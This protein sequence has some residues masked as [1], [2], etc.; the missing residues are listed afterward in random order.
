S[1]GTPPPPRGSMSRRPRRI[2]SA[3]RCSARRTAPAHT[4]LSVWGRRANRSSPG[5]RR[6]G[7]CGSSGRFTSGSSR[8]WASQGGGT[9]PFPPRNRA[10]PGSSQRKAGAAMGRRAEMGDLALY[11]RLVRQ[12]APSWRLVGGVFL[13]GLLASPLALL[14][15]LPLKIAVDTLLGTHPLPHALDALLPE[16]MRSTSGLLVLVAALAVV[17]TVSSQLQVA[18]QKYLT[19]L[20]G[21]RLQLDFRAQIFRHLQRMSLSYH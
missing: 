14:A 2:R 3:S 18:A 6:P 12:V 15:P 7:A 19:V 20:A 5:A 1:P 4:A 8:G 11:R 16:G 9:T 13:V 21:E 10:S 17:L